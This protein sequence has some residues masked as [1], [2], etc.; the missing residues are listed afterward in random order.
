MI[1]VVASAV[2]IPIMPVSE[3]TIIETPNPT[4]CSLNGADGI[5]AKIPYIRD[6]IVAVDDDSTTMI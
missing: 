3:Q 6:K 2:K 5:N 1:M 4:S